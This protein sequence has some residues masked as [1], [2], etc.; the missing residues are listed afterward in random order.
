MSYMNMYVYIWLVNMWLITFF[1]FFIVHVNEVIFLT[2]Y[3]SEIAH[4]KF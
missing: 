4:S 1:V 3:Q 2:W